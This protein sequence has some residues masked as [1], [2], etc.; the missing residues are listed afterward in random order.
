MD[1]NDIAMIKLSEHVQMSDEVQLA[2]LPAPGTLL[3]HN[4]PCY[5]T[6]WGVLSSKT[7]SLSFCR[8][9]CPELKQSLALRRERILL[10]IPKQRV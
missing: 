1:S 9:T 7:A 3:P 6:G 4:Y 5:I 10:L 8:V 2:C